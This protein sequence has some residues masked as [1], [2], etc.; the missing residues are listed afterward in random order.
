M[1]NLYMVMLLNKKAA[2]RVNNCEPPL[3]QDIDLCFIDGMV[4][5][6]P[7]FERLED[8]DKY[9]DGANIVEIELKL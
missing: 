8:A 4:G 7:V 9:A 3:E 1:S 2:V 5:A 6:I